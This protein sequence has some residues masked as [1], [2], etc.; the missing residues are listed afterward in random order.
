[1]TT[2][3]APVQSLA[4]SADGADGTPLDSLSGWACKFVGGCHAACGSGSSCG[5][6]WLCLLM[7]SMRSCRSLAVNFQLNGRAVWLY[8][9]MK[10]SR[11]RDSGTSEAVEVVGRNDFLLDD[12]EEDLDLV[13]PRGVYRG[14]DHDGV[15]VGSGQPGDG[16]LAAVV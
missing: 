15:R 3:C 2:T 4:G 11:V 5:S 14:V 16:G 10:A 9:S 7:R 8:R 12:G 6:G 13:Q 1:M